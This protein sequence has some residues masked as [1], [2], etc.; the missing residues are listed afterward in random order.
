MCGSDRRLVACARIDRIG[1][2]HCQIG[3]RALGNTTTIVRTVKYETTSPTQSLS[4][5]SATNAVISG[6]GSSYTLYYRSD[7]AGSFTIADAVTDGASGPKQ[8][9]FPAI[10]TTGWTHNSETDRKSTRLNS[11]HVSESRMPS[12]A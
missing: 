9:V 4:L 2:K 8:V 10:S 1:V 12:S 7:L 6:S 5:A 3:K 11:S